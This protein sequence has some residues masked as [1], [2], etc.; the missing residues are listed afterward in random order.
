[1]RLEPHFFIDHVGP[2]LKKEENISEL[3]EY[4]MKCKRICFIVHSTQKYQPHC[5]EM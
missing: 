5:N 1:M 3:H 4:N 2:S